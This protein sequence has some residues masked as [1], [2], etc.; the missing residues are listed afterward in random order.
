M[1]FALL[2]AGCFVAGFLAD[3]FIF[4]SSSWLT[5]SGRAVVAGVAVVL[6]GL[7]LALYLGR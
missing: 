5:T 7:G 2:Y 4:H 1:K 6:I 3:R